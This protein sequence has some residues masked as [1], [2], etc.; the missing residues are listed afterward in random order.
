MAEFIKD[1]KIKNSVTDK[2][3]S[4]DAKGNIISTD[5]TVSELVT[6]DT[7]DALAERISSLE[8]TTS[9]MG[10]RLQSINGEE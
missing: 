2:V 7:T 10:Q 1:L 9:T 5:K 4:V 8:T 6:N 3:L